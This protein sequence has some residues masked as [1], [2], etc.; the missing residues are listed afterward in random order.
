MIQKH[1]VTVRPQVGLAPDKLPHRIESQ[2][3]RSGNR[4]IATSGRT[5]A[6]LGGRIVWAVSNGSGANI[7]NYGAPLRASR[8]FVN[9]LTRTRK[10]SIE[11]ATN[12]KWSATHSILA[13]VSTPTMAEY[14]C[15]D[16]PVT[17]IFRLQHGGG[18]YIPDGR[19]SARRE[20][21]GE[22]SLDW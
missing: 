1:L 8:L 17:L 21:V 14:I 2:L 7:G 22:A 19:S 3:P 6:S 13:R 12:R 18:P 15:A 20:D 11:T 5:A 4:G 10:K 16:Q 9:D